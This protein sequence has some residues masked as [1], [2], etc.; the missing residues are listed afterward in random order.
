MADFK[1]LEGALASNDRD[2][3]DNWKIESQ[4]WDD[5]GLNARAAEFI[6]TQND[7]IHVDLG[8][9]LGRL[10]ATLNDTNPQSVL[11][12]VDYNPQMLYAGGDFLSNSGKKPNYL[13]NTKRRMNSSGQIERIFDANQKTDFR[14]LHPLERGTINLLCDD[15]RRLSVL[16]AI[17]GDRKLSSGSLLLPGVCVNSAFE[18]PYP[19]DRATEEQMSHRK[20]AVAESTRLAAYKFMT[21]QVA[22]GGKF[23]TAERIG[24][25]DDLDTPEKITDEMRELLG[26]F[27]QYWEMGACKL[28]EEDLGHGQVFANAA[29]RDG[30]LRVENTRGSKI[31]LIAPKHSADEATRITVILHQWVRNNLK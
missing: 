3:L 12:G 21:E 10:L 29:E 2:Y 26:P 4:V 9:G 28:L 7:G 6:G 19:P 30:N 5:L 8:T 27:Q 15:V 1:K 18:A 22:P 11:F 31:D 14:K 25:P 20:L 13:I 23:V 17:L 16:R 24:V